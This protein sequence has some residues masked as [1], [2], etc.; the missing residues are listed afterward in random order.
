[1]GQR[2]TRDLVVL[3][4]F[5]LIVRA[6]TAAFIQRPGYMDPSY[7]AAGAVNLAEGGGL[8]EPHIWNYLDDPAGVPHPGFL[9]W[10]PLPSLLAAPFAALFPDSFFALQIPFVVLSALLPLV[11]YA[12]AWEATGRRRHAWFAALIVVFSGFF[13]PHWTLPETFA[14]FA[15][16]GS[17]ALWMATKREWWA[18]LLVGLSVG[19]AHLTRADGVILL[20]LVALAPWLPMSRTTHHASQ[21]P[22]LALRLVVGHWS[23]VIVGYLFVTTPW[24]IRNLVAIGTLLPP[25]GTKTLWLTRYDDLYCYGCDLS[26]WSYLAWGWENIL[27]SKL[28]AA[29]VNFQRFLGENC[30][31]FLLPFVFVGVYRLRRQSSLMFSLIYL[32]AAYLAHSLAFTYPGLRGG[33]FH[34]SAPV[35][36]FLYAAAAEGLDA[37][38][39][40]VGQRRRWN[41][42]QAQVVFATAAIVAAVILSGYAGWGKVRG[43][44]DVDRAYEEIGVWLVGQ[45]VGDGV[46]M[47]N[48]PPAFWYYT[49]RKAVVLP[50]NDV[51]TLLAVADRY[52]VAYV[53]L[54]RQV[55]WQLQSMYRREESHLR[56]QQVAEFGDGSARVALYRVVR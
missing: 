49:H 47:A 25:G 10:M 12:V 28:F 19:M 48:N 16:F 11:G 31:V 40:W 30:L 44:Q 8:S 45:G 2:T 4:L 34:A 38:V 13:F 56:L 9:Y 51:E 36:P 3:L 15:L 29:G 20:P 1:V 46:V 42:L 33:F 22:R 43:W 54:D 24:F 35:L 7:Y 37:V 50:A 53:V 39:G 17:F 14:P 52:D 27:Q 32:L 6:V 41:V 55:P 26:L 21:T 18:G 5:A 23:L